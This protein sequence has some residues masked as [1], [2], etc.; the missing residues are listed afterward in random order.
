MKGVVGGESER[1]QLT[2]LR[3]GN[4]VLPS[5]TGTTECASCSRGVCPRL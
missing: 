5:D 4:D 2:C 3:C 1:R